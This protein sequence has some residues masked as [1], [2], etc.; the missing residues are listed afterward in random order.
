MAGHDNMFYGFVEGEG[1]T[2]RDWEKAVWLEQRWW[3]QSRRDRSQ[4]MPGQMR[5]A[6]IY[7]KI[8]EK[9]PASFK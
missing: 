7:S 8:S 4:I 9:T 5:A 3:E 6:Y 1:L 2:N